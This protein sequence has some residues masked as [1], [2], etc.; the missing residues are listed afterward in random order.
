MIGF[1][2]GES[3]QKEGFYLRSY[4][5]AV[6]ECGRPIDVFTRSWGAD[7]PP[8]VRMGELF[9][10]RFRVEIKYNGEQYGPPY[11]VAGGMMAGWHAYSYQNY[12]TFPRPYEVIHQVRFNG[13]HRVFPWGNAELV[14]ITARNARLGGSIGIT[15]EP[16]NAYYPAYDYQTRDDSPL[17]WYLWTWQRDWMFYDV[18]GR[19][20]YDPQV[21]RRV[22]AAKFKAR[23]GEAAGEA[24]FEAFDAAGRIIP[25]ALAVC[26]MHPDH[27]GHAIELETGGDVTRWAETLPFDAANFQSPLEYARS[28][29]EGAPSPRIS[30]LQ[31]ADQ[32]EAWCAE[33][34]K[35]LDRVKTP[36]AESGEIK[37][38][39]VDLTMQTHL[40]RYVAARL[41]SA[42]YY[43]LYSLSHDEPFAEE[44][45][46]HHAEAVA[47]WGR[48][49]SVGESKYKPFVDT[50]RMKTE[51]YTWA[52][53]AAKCR[54]DG[55]ALADQLE[56]ALK[57]AAK[58]DAPPKGLTPVSL[59]AKGDKTG[60]VIGAAAANLATAAQGVRKLTVQVPVS[61]P[62]GLAAVNLRWKPFPSEAVWRTAPMK[63]SGG[64]WSAAVGVYPFG[65]L[66]SV[67]A[68]D[69]D[70][71]AS[72]WPD[73]RRDIPYRWVEPWKDVALV[74]LPMIEMV[75]HLAE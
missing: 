52:Q 31:A 62:A 8:I 15:V 42:T 65:I 24:C 43:A 71:N 20:S 41:R 69:K 70:G 23:Y 13:T 25:F 17:K 51:T 33:V 18:W 75:G 3:G 63:Q 60:P 2:I 46:K 53:E 10:G 14:G 6:Q 55:T 64:M 47:Q 56:P 66:W 50:L 7:K 9:P 27:R 58:P 4:V 26:G 32:I 36:G 61:D 67:D 73:C 38:L 39:C 11:L 35:H 74:S 57:K 29:V 37:S 19:M 45:R 54:Q 12:F 5:P 59:E 34:T 48:L 30:P 28:V 68:L 16:P 1:R 72:L 44:A 49:A 40:G 22:W 21:P